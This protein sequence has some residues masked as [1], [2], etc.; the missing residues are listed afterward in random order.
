MRMCQA[1]FCLPSVAMWPS[2]AGSQAASCP[3]S[4]ARC[5]DIGVRLGNLFWFVL[6]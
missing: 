2:Q 5:G 1:P 6:P 4:Y 3:L